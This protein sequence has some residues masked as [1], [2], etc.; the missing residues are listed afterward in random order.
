MTTVS[1]MLIAI[2]LVNSLF[3]ATFIRDLYLNPGA[4]RQDNANGLFLTCSSPIIFFLSTFGISDFA[5]SSIVYRKKNLVADRLL[6]GT[7]NT[8]C[9]IPVAVMALSFITVIQVDI[10]TLIACI[11]AQVIGAHVG[12]RIVSKLSTRVIRLMIGVGLLVAT[13]VVAAGLLHLIPS[14]G[15]ATKLTGYKLII[16]AICLFIFGILNNVGIGSYAPTMVTVYALGLHPSVAFPIMMGASTF[17]VPVG[18]MQFIKYGLYS[19]KITLY[20]TSLGLIGVLVGV[21]F[22]GELDLSR[23][24]WLVAAILL[25]SGISMLVNEMRSTC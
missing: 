7:L 4:L 1:Y 16:A 2:V 3:L 15:T 18:S 10:I 11:A 5:I 20:T 17:A 14:A 25:Y 9:V 21:T 8:Q 24:Q 13:A 19:R 22:V 23:L 6:P 12:P